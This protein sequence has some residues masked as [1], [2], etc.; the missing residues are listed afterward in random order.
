[1]Q[2]RISRRGALRG[3]AGLAL[4]AALSACGA[5]KGAGSS[6]ND[7]LMS[8]AQAGNVAA[9]QG[10]LSDGADVNAF[11]YTEGRSART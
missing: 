1:M 9:I 4:L 10:A 6:A 8:A 3:A 11:D 5:M 7:Q 2:P